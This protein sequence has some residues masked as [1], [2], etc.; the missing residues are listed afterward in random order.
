MMNR[1]ERTPSQLGTA[2][3]GTLTVAALQHVSRFLLKDGPRMDVVGEKIIEKGFRRFGR[4][5]PENSRL[6][7]WVGGN[8]GS[9]TLVFALVG[10][11]QPKR[12]VVRGA[13]V[14]A[15]TG[16]GALV[17]P[18]LL[19]ITSRHTAKN[20]KQ[21]AMTVGLYLIAGLAAGA[22]HQLAPAFEDELTS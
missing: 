16:L 18:P 12:P 11:G 22:A 3:V 19:G 8:I 14:G 2:L 1:S 9:D 17:L 20:P 7:S 10:M 5:P 13:I 15:L 6:L 21:A 4:K